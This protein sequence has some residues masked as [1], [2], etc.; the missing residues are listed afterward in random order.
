MIAAR[1]TGDRLA[2]IQ[3][4]LRRSRR[5]L[6]ALLV[7]SVLGIASLGIV[8][9][10]QEVQ[11]PWQD[12]Y[13]VRVAFDDVKGV[14]PGRQHVRIAGVNVGK[15]VGSG[16]ENGRAVL[17]LSFDGRHAPLYR[18]AV[19]RLRPATPLDD[20]YV[21]VIE[22]G[23]PA[24]GEIGQDELLVSGRTISP[25]DIGAVLDVFQPEERARMAALLEGLGEGMPDGGHQLRAS[26]ASTVPFLKAAKRLSD[27]LA[28]RERQTR[29]LVHNFRRLTEALGGRDRRLAVLVRGGHVALGEL[30]AADQ[31]LARTLEEL[32]PLLTRMRSAMTALRSAQN[33]L[34]PALGELGGVATAMPGGMRALHEFS[35]DALPALEALEGPVRRLVPLVADLRPVA[36]DTQSAFE[37]LRPQ[38]PRFD[39]MSAALLPC[40]FAVGKF[41]QW[42]ASVFKFYDAYGSYPRGESVWGTNAAGGA[43]RDLNLRRSPSCTDEP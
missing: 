22:R 43:N 3:L 38:A 29:R 17:S 35:D 6:A 13:Q 23:T 21:D 5:N 26:F 25:V 2:R 30:A 42:T 20:M 34:D 15:I 27:V 36:V 24:A 8:L 10:N 39:R 14:V 11:W 40:R 33:E 1:R 7:L 4:E 19:V 9:R 18:D 31:P 32:P 28:R 12:T 37:L 16:L 41:F